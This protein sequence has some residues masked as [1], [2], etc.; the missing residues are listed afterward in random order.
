MWLVMGQRTRVST[1]GRRTEA[2]TEAT[3]PGKMKYD[4]IGIE[5]SAVYR[6]YVLPIDSLSGMHY[7][8]AWGCKLP[9]LK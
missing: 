3:C 2:I 9:I 7:K 8:N 4:I 6:R 1:I 5:L